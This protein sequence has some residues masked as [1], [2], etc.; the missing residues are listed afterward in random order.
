MHTNTSRVLTAF[1]DLHHPGDQTFLPNR[2][3]LD[4]LHRYATMFD[5][6]PRIRL[7]TQGDSAT[8]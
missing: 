1:S 4:Y 3:V 2:D 8:A 6:N 7:G 5:L